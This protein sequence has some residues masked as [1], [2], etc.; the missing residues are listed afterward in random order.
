MIVSFNDK[1]NYMKSIVLAYLSDH[2]I[3]FEEYTHPPLFTVEQASEWEDK[4]PGAHSKNIF[5]KTKK[6]DYNLISLA[7]H[8]K[9]DTKMFK[10]QSGVKDFSFASPEQLL[11]QLQ[12]TPWSVWLFGLLNNPS[13]Q[14]YIDQDLRTAPK[15]W[16]HP[17]DNT[18]TIVLDHAWLERFIEILGIKKNVIIL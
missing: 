8:K 5:I 17:N 18:S 16:R 9:L 13:I 3:W 11:E 2:S 7:A 12:L 10:L 14:Y 15:V 4:I 6:W 1:K